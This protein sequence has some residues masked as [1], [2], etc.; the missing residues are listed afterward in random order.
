LFISFPF[1]CRERGCHTLCGYLIALWQQVAV[2]R[3]HRR[4]RVADLGVAPSYRELGLVV[5]W[6]RESGMEDLDYDDDLVE[7]AEANGSGW[8]EALDLSTAVAY[9]V[10]SLY[11]GPVKLRRLRSSGE[12]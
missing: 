11:A 7:L 10:E 4:R 12:R 3:E 2:G 6:L 9:G 5:N 8:H 1:S